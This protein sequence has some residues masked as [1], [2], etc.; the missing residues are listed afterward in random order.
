VFQAI[1]GANRPGV[2]AYHA[3]SIQKVVGVGDVV[4]GRA[5]TNVMISDYSFSGGDVAVT[6]SYSGGTAIYTFSTTPVPEP[7]GV[8]LAS[9]VAAGLGCAW[10]NRRAGWWRTPA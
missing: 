7:G 9:G 4:D 8:L 3:G 5:V 6:L 1:D 10:R 2:Y